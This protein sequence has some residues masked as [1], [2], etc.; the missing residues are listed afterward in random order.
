MEDWIMATLTAEQKA[1]K[2]DEAKRKERRAWAKQ[3]I[4]LKKAVEKGIVA[5]DAEIDIYVKA[6]YAK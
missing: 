4:L 5:T 3:A 6:H 2:W 1:A